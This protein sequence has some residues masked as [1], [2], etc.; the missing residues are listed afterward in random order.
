MFHICALENESTVQSLIFGLVFSGWDTGCSR[1]CMQIVEEKKAN[2]MEQVS[3]YK[4]FNNCKI[5]Y[6]ALFAQLCF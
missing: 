1:V 3:V 2:Q 6:N 4:H 5:A